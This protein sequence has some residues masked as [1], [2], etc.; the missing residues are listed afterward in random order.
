MKA[1]SG[2]AALQ[3]AEQ[4]V[5]FVG[6]VEV[7]FEV[8]G[9]EFLAEVFD[10]AG[11]EIESG[12]E[13]IFVGENDVA[14]SGV[15][16]ASEAKGIAEAGAGQ[17]DRQTVFVEMIV[18]KRGKGDGGE[19]GEMRDEADGVIVLLGAE[20]QRMGADFFEEFEKGRD[21]RVVIA[22]RSADEGVGGVAE[23]VGVGIGDAGLFAAGHGMAGE[24]EL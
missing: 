13:E 9:G 11:K 19:L 22:R 15:G 17:S 16:A 24:E 21:A 5:E 3:G 6:G 8:A 23:K 2:V 1:P 4:L 18:K 14:P 7:G 20:P 10:A 12:G